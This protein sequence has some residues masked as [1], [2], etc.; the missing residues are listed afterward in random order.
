MGDEGIGDH[1]GGLAPRAGTGHGE[2][3]GDIAV[4]DVGGDLHDESGQLG[5][6]Q[7]A[8]GHGAWQ[9]RSAEHGPHPAPPDGDCSSGRSFQSLSFSRSFPVNRLLFYQAV[10]RTTSLSLRAIRPPSVAYATSPSGRRESFLLG[11]MRA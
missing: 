3:G 2:V 7:G 1:L 11:E 10:L 4:L 8:V 9:P 6:G 5:F